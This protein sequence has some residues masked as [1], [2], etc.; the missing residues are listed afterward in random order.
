MGPLIVGHQRLLTPLC[1]NS[2]RGIFHCRFAVLTDTKYIVSDW[3]Q[4][5][6][7]LRQ[8]AHQI[9]R[10]KTIIVM[11]TQLERLHVSGSVSSIG[12]EL[13]LNARGHRF[14]KLKRFD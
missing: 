1:S 5:N 2:T 13:S 8:T 10:N 12:R 14:R 9:P 7:G 6:V 4:N 11:C 3:M